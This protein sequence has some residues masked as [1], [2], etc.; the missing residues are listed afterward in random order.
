M[1]I[2]HA[3]RSDA[4]TFLD[5]VR[6]LAEY[7]QLDP[8]DEQAQ[9]RL[10][11]D[12]FGDRRRFE[13]YLVEIDGEAVGYAI[14]FE[15]YSS[16]LARP[17]LYLEDIFVRPQARRKGA[18]TALIRYLAGEAIR[19]GCGRMEWV[20]LDWNELAQGVYRKLGAEMLGEWR[21]CRLT[22]AALRQAACG[23]AMGEEGEG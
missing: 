1:R 18:G 16:F 7:E 10:L 2:R 14:V 15:T 13:A 6:G 21:I 9:A 3:E 4:K 20:V 12:G 5:L 22:G 17:S 8:P 11:E 19:R 23:G